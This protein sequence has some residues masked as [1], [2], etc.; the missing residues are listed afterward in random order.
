M[1]PVDLLRIA[2]HLAMGGASGQRGRPRQADLRRAVSTVYYALFHTLEACGANLL[3]GSTPTNRSEPAWPQTYRALDHGLAQRQ[4]TDRAL[5]STLQRF[6]QDIQ[7]F[8]STFVRMQGQRHRADYDPLASFSR[9]EVQLWIRETE[10]AIGK[11]EQTNRQDRC[12]FAVFVL[13]RL[14]R[15]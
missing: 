7:D 1:D 11:F 5:K 2:N 8:A 15:S 4:C 10:Q 9:F 3:V 12:A 14:R 13:F 6:P